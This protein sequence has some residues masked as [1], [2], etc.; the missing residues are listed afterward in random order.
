MAK[1]FELSLLSGVEES[2]FEKAAFSEVFPNLEILRRNV[3]RTSH[4]LLKIDGADSGNCRYIWLV[5]AS[6]V[7]DTP[8]TAGKGPD[9]LASDLN[10]VD[11]ASQLFAKYA[12]IS[13]FH[14]VQQS[15]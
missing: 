4:R 1:C 2:T 10:F 9:V 8:E 14:E 7:G 3:R 13:S 12:T 11:K 6:L 15:T 5:F